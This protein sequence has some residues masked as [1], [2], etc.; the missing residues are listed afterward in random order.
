MSEPETLPS[1]VLYTEP[2]L[3]PYTKTYQTIIT[4]DGIPAGPLGEMVR[5]VHTP[6]LS[7]FSA[8]GFG[9]C[10]YALMRTRHPAHATYM[11]PEDIP[12]VFAYLLANG[13]EID[14]AI[15]ERLVNE[16]SETRRPIVFAVYKVIV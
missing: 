8:Y 16:W 1:F 5:R 3:N 11:F 4:L 15:T 9:R 12:N 6:R 2:A 14:H 7:E 10:M 13:Y